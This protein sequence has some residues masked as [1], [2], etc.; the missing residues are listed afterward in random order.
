[1]PK[2]LMSKDN[3]D[4]WKLEDLLETIKDELQEKSDRLVNDECR[5]SK[6]LRRN[7]SHIGALLDVAEKIQR[8]SMEQLDT[9]GEDQ[10]PTGQRRV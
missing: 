3:P 2:L 8:E 9:L 7:N 1:M 4:G 10:G 6:L 5:V